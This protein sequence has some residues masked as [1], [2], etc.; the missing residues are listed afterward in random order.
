MVLQAKNEKHSNLQHFIL[1][2]Y[3]LIQVCLDSIA[4]VVLLPC[5]HMCC[6]QRCSESLRSCPVCRRKTEKKIQAFLS[7][8]R[9]VWNLIMLVLFHS[10]DTARAL[11]FNCVNFYCNFFNFC[12]RLPLELLPKHLFDKNCEVF[13]L[14]TFY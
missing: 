9:I 8:E 4:N 1:S 12:S 11:F 7:W 14:L 3:Q 10:S 13:L 2:Y 6:C 5:R